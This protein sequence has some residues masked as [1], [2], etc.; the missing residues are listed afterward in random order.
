M[1]DVRWAMGENPACHRPSHVAKSPI[2]LQTLNAD[3]QIEFS[4]Q[5]AQR[6]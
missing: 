5:S 2:L 3:G 6:G 1:A 4:T